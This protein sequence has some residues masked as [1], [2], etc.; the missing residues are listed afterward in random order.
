[1]GQWK[2]LTA[3]ISVAFAGVFFWGSIVGLFSL[4]HVT[5]SV[6]ARF[7][8]QINVGV[9]YYL[10]SLK[11]TLFLCC[12]SVLAAPIVTD[13]RRILANVQ[14][15]TLRNT[16]GVCAGVAILLGLM[17]LPAL[18]NQSM[19]EGYAWRS[20]APFDQ[21][22]SNYSK[23]LF[24]PAIAH[25]LFFREGWLYYLFFN[26]V[27]LVFL[28]VLY[29]WLR[30][31]TR[32]KP[33]H[34]LSL[35]T[36]SFVVFQYQFPGYPDI[37]MFTFFVLVMT[38]E[39]T[40]QSKLSF[41]LLA[42]ATHFLSVFVGTVLAYRYLNRSCRLRYFVAAA[43]YGVIWL[44]AYDFNFQKIFGEHN[45]ILG[46][47]AQDWLFISPLAEALGVFIAFK[48][49]WWL[50]ILAMVLALRRRLY[51]EAIFMAG[52]VFAGLLITFLGVDTSRHMAVAFPGVLVALE[53]IGKHM[54]QRTGNRIFSVV[55]SV[56]MIIPSF[57]VGLNMWIELR[58]GLY[59]ILYSIFAQF[60]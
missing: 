1:M 54:P 38:P 11:G 3:R 25:V 26:F 52:C 29:A 42:L 58:P 14:K 55:F 34:F 10:P 41:L 50:L 21:D 8:T 53:T 30:N 56:N 24:M 31:H 48:A 2:P 47:S 59:E 49:V 6:V 32:V 28:S 5:R 15:D 13:S 7:V 12:V 45:N 51:R 46:M 40:Q 4:C 9:W 39:Y 22:T 44:A 36:C 19:G 16:L 33:W 23:Q 27:F 17:V 57:Y 20:L 35:S 37:L 43:L 18:G 60:G